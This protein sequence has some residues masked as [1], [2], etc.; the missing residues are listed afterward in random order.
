[1]GRKLESLAG[2]VVDRPSPA[3]LG[4]VASRPARWKH[5]DATYNAEE[6]TWEY[7]QPWPDGLAIDCGGFRMPVRP[8]PY[9]HIG[10]FPEQR[11]NW[12]WLG[13][14]LEPDA[15]GF[16]QGNAALNLFAYT[17]AST[18]ALARAGF[19]VAHV[20][21]A[22]PNVQSARLAAE[23]NNLGEAVIRY[24][25]DDAAKFA[26]R[27]LRRQRKYHTILMDPPAYGHSPKGKAWRLERDLWPLLSDCLKLLDRESFRLLVTGHSPQVEQQEI[28]EFLRQTEFLKPLRGSSRLIIEAGRSQLRDEEDRSLDAGFFV[29][30]Q[31]P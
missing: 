13:I 18:V 1:M 27:E 8:T 31:M 16:V 17:G 11:E 28:L 24:L 12:T 10:L 22:K 21:A 23:T 26:A 2:Y 7:H 30:L 3:A 20:D 25:V 6:R 15:K 5:A 29:R 19:S 14:R 4:T 9:G